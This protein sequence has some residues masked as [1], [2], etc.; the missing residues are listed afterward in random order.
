MRK[1]FI[2]T[3]GGG[4]IGREV[5]LGIC[6]RGDSPVIIDKDYARAKE[7]EDLVT[8]FGIEGTAYTADLTKADEVKEVF[9]EIY[10][11]FKSID[12][13]VN[14]AGGYFAPISIDEM[15]AEIWDMVVDANLK[16]AFLC[17]LEAFHYMKPMRHGKI[18]NL[19]STLFLTS[20][21]SLSPYISAKGGVVG[22]TRALAVD[23]GAFNIN[24]NAIAPGLTSTDYAYE[25]LGRERFEIVKQLKA[26]KK[27]QTPGDLVGPILFLLSSDS[28]SITGQTLIVDGGRA[29]L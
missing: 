14:N 2:V 13:L 20:G 22:L 17:S 10:H 28:D 26:I 3:G 1:V 6:K 11:D 23:M 21:M 29:F 5:A 16:S 4:G 12:G 9:A 15:N 19:T 24:V 8:G 27:D 25:A 18:V 7:T